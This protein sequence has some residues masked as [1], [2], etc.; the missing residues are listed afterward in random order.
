MSLKVKFT[1]CESNTHEHKI[2]WIR[3]HS[4]FFR[5]Y[6]FT[7]VNLMKSKKPTDNSKQLFKIWPR[8]VVWNHTIN[9]TNIN[10]KHKRNEWVSERLMCMCML[11][12]IVY[13]IFTLPFVNL[14]AV[15]QS[16]SPI[17]VFFCFCLFVCYYDK[18]NVLA[19]CM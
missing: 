17:K 15:K 18:V 2:L 8:W 16:V 13:F 3:M 12:F 1:V 11:L 9:T 14:S 6:V 7:T 10:A 4:V 5:Q 19:L